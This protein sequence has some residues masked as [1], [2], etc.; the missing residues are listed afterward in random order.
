MN[1]EE[2]KSTP[3][4][5]TDIGLFAGSKDNFADIWQGQLSKRTQSKLD[6]LTLL[7]SLKASL[8]S[9]LATQ[10]NHKFLGS[11]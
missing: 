3:Q 7:N 5:E 8:G 9:N 4:K 10:T 2:Q 11:H 6:K 1:T